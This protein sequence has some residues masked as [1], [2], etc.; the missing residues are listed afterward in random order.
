MRKKASPQL[1]P[2]VIQV[3]KTRLKSPETGL[4]FTC[5]YSDVPTDAY[6]WVIDLKYLPISFD[7]MELAI[8]D[9]QKHVYGW[10][11]GKK[12]TGLKFKKEYI[13]VKWKRDMNYDRI[14]H[15]GEG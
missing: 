13:V 8:R 14:E 9:K 1:N 5:K 7:M 10:W 3:S 6:G 4:E 15:Y 2:K 11:D 12:W